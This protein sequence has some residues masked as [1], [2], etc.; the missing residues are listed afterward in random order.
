MAGDKSGGYMNVEEKK[1]NELLPFPFRLYVCRAICAFHFE[2]GA[3]SL[4][5]S[6]GCL[7]EEEFDVDG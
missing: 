5:R 2:L 3:N 1:R 6:N 7:T 4:G